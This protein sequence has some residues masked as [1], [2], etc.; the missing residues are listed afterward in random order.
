MALPGFSA[1]S[2][3]Y[4]TKELY[5]GAAAYARVGRSGQ[6]VPSLAARC[7][8]SESG[9]CCFDWGGFCCASFTGFGYF[10][11]DWTFGCRRYPVAEA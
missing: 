10:C 1:A 11:C 8:C 7:I 2:S 9:C 6:V 3:L 4:K 5:L